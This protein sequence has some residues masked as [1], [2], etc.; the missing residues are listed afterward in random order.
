LEEAVMQRLDFLAQTAS[1]HT[2][3]LDFVR[4]V[5]QYM[6]FYLNSKEVFQ[7][8]LA[9]LTKLISFKPKSWR[10]KDFFIPLNVSLRGADLHTGSTT[11]A[12]AVKYWSFLLG[13]WHKSSF[14]EG[15]YN[16]SVSRQLHIYMEWPWSERF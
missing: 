9:A 5:T 1:Y 10:N 13:M 14:H 3:I 12:L 8:G 4:E 2:K 16:R 15:Y 7:K 6:E 11:F